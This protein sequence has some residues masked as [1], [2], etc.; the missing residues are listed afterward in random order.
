MLDPSGRIIYV[1]KA[2][3]LRTRLLGYFRVRS[4]DP[5]A[6]RIIA[7]TRK[8]IW[9]STPNEFGALLRELELIQSLRPRFN[10]IGQPGARRY[11]YLC[12]GRPPAPT[13]YYTRTPTG[14]EE[15]CYG[16]FTGAKRTAIAAKVLNDLY[17]LRDCAQRQKLRFADEPDL[18]EFTPTPG[19]L[20][21]EIATCS[22]P[23]VAACSRADY[24]RQV[25]EAKKLLS[26]ID[27]EPIR[28]LEAE[29]L[30]F[31]KQQEYEKAAR[32]KE[33]WEVLSHL[34][35]RLGFLR[36]AREEHSFI[37]ATPCH[38]GRTVWFV[39]H[40]GII[41]SSCF[42]PK[43]KRIREK[44]LKEIQRIFADPLAARQSTLRNFDTVLLVTAWF[45]RFP[46]ERKN[47]LDSAGLR[48]ENAAG[49]ISQ[50]AA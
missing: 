5:K 42:E 2:K 10:V 17:R 30:A 32:V 50:P 39:I 46:E 40:R 24:N 7:R 8:I 15:A 26:G 31:S 14:R 1:G 23:C 11:I 43:S 35:E 19:C 44:S 9:E 4:R 28:R 6:G 38:D 29:M 37:Y 20:R 41:Q 27:A 33:K 45:R 16:P 22:G 12:V 34:R 18:F 47:L 36:R 13:I 21:Y 48:N 49:P 25:K 3:S